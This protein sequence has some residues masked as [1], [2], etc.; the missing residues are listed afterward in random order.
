MLPARPAPELVLTM[1]AATGE[2]ALACALQYST[3]WRVMA[4]VPLRWTRMTASHSSS[5]IDTIMRSRTMPALL[6]TV[7]RRPH[8]SM[9]AATRWAAPS[10]LLTSS[11]L[12]MASPPLARIASTTSPAGPSELPA[13]SSD[14][15]TSFT[16][17]RA[18]WRANS[19]AWARPMPR[20]APVTITTRPSQ[21][22]TGSATLFG[23]HLER[24]RGDVLGRHLLGDEQPEGEERH[25]AEQ[26]GAHRD[27]LG[28]DLR[29]RVVGGV[30]DRHEYEDGHPWQQARHLVV[31]QLVVHQE[32]DHALR[33]VRDAQQHQQRR[34]VCEPGAEQHLD[35]QP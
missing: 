6:T 5:A 19:R 34:R 14:T 27:V 18:P 16:T 31:G 28:G 8:R 17:T 32:A 9:A 12:A 30:H 33:P 35:D 29:A 3:A 25:G 21:I 26:R 24:Q 15:P 2:P 1:R 7:S 13:P 10:Q 22:P 11:P 23:D 4:N 20:P